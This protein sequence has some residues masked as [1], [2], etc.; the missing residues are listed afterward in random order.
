MKKLINTAFIYGG[1]ALASGVFYREFTKMLGFTGRTVLATTHIHFFVLGA[2]LFLLLA[3]FSLNTN[4]TE[5]KPFKTF[6]VVYNISLP[7][8]VAMFYVRGILQVLG[9]T[10]SSGA[11][12]A[13]SGVSGLTHIALTVGLVFLAV[14]FKKMTVK[15]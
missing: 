9:T 7:L 2:V 15:K 5:T 4:I 13:I 1:A 11:N 3:A 8:M 14:S 6:F 12:A 10:L